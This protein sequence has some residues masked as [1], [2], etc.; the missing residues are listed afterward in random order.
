MADGV[1]SGLRIADVLDRSRRLPSIGEVDRMSYLVPDDLAVEVALVAPWWLM[2]LIEFTP[3]QIENIECRLHS[4]HWR[5][6]MATFGVG[7]CA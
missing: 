1:T 7:V 6:S 2:P 5:R 4:E 3:T